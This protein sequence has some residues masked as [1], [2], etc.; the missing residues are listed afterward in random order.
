MK[1]SVVGLAKLHNEAEK[2]ASDFSLWL[3]VAL[4]TLKQTGVVAGGLCLGLML[5]G[6]PP[7]ILEEE[8]NVPYTPCPPSY[9]LTQ[10][11]HC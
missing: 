5:S 3:A 8:A 4:V 10:D 11:K 1:C 2:D 9:V 7:H 6:P